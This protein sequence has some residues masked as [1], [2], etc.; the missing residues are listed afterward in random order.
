MV[1]L[2]DKA[3]NKSNLT[4]TGVLPVYEVITASRPKP[5]LT[6]DTVVILSDLAGS[7]N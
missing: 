4:V 7:N 2:I 6:Q 3:G 5:A 1:N